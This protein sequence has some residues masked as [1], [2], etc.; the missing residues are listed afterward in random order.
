MCSQ[1]NKQTKV[2]ETHHEFGHLALLGGQCFLH[3]CDTD[4]IFCLYFHFRP[5]HSLTREL[6]Q[7]VSSTR[8]CSPGTW[9]LLDDSWVYLPT[10]DIQK[11]VGLADVPGHSL[12]SLSGAVG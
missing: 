2:S 5:F 3:V 12:P 11:G 8:H 7:N 4:D 9:S 10:F 1:T 6:F